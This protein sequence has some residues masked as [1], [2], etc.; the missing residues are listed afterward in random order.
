M[1]R[2]PFLS[3]LPMAFYALIFQPQRPVLKQIPPFSPSVLN[4]VWV[5]DITYIQTGEGWLYLCGSGKFALNYNNQ[6]QVACVWSV[7]C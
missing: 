3:M 5:T 2:F 6:K 7:N 1:F 4:E